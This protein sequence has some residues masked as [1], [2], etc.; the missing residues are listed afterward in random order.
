MKPPYSGYPLQR[1]PLYNGY[2]SQERIKWSSN[3]HNKSSMYR[4][5]YSR[6]LSVVGI[7][8]RSQLTLIPRTDLSIADASNIW[9]FLKD[10]CI[11][12][13]LDNVLQFRLNF[14]RSLL[15][16]FSAILMAFSGPWKCRGFKFVGIFSPYSSLW[17]TCFPVAKMF[18]AQWDRDRNL[19]IIIEI[20]VVHG[21]PL[22]LYSE[23]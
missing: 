8:F 16:Y 22:L 13:S 9:H 15:F 3:S 7:P 6:H 18:K 1:T 17:L 2:F 21:Q 14:L 12:F 10:I 11:H 4:T 23:N 5:L 19:D 20:S